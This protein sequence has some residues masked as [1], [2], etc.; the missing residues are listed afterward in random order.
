M[1]FPRETPPYKMIVPT[2]DTVRNSYL[3]SVCI[4]ARTNILVVGDTGTS[5]TVV[6]QQQLSS[7]PDSFSSLILNFSSAT[8]SN[9]TQDI[10]ESAMEKRAKDKLGPIG[11][12]QLV[13]F[14]DDLNMPR[15]DDFGSQPPL[16]LLR[17]WIDYG[18]WY[19]RK[20][21]QLRYI[22]DMQLIAAMGPPGGGR[23]EISQ[24]LQSRFHLVNFTFPHDNEIKRIFET[25][26]K[27]N[28]LC[29]SSSFF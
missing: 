25:M 16:E 5:K 3:V 2:V 13:T 7:L 19:D 4:N 23:S 22:L 18:C 10:I 28:Y 20:K 11:G 1:R 29:S 24:R 17:Q 14:V 27:K 26:V 12:K 6:V 9:A 8:S 15:K 21:Q